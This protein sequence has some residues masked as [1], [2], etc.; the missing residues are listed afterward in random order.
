MLTKVSKTWKKLEPVH[1]WWECGMMWPLW[2][3]RITKIELSHDPAI[4]LHSKHDFKDFFSP[5]FIAVYSKQRTSDSN[6][7]VSRKWNEQMKYSAHIQ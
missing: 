3:L 1:C 5:V 7:S 2:L 6:L 4:P